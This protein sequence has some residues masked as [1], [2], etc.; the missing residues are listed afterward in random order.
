MKTINSILFFLMLSI[1][2]SMY[3]GEASNLP[4]NNDPLSRELAELLNN[5]GLIITEDFTVKIF[6]TVT[7]ERT[8]E[9]KSISSENEVV[10]EFLYKRLQ[11]QQLK[12]NSWFSEKLYELPVKVRAQ[13]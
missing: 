8:I 10:N 6:F 5:S 12:G 13:R 1:S 2:A 7:E 4:R 3:A 11:G 9:I